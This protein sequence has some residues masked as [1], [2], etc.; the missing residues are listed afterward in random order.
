MTVKRCIGLVVDGCWF[1]K[2]KETLGNPNVGVINIKEVV[3]MRAVARGAGNGSRGAR[4]RAEQF[5]RQ[6]NVEGGHSSREEEEEGQTVGS[7]QAALREG[8]L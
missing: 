7:A 6:G 8:R 5:T 2:K 1:K 4:R 3:R